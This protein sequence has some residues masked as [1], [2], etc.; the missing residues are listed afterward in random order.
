MF[1][2]ISLENYR[3]RYE[4]VKIDEKVWEMLLVLM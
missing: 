1:L 2:L 3:M 4:L